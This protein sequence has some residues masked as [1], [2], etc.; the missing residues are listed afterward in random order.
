MVIVAGKAIDFLGITGFLIL[1]KP[2]I[3]SMYHRSRLPRNDGVLNTEAHLPFVR[4]SFRYFSKLIEPVILIINYFR[5]RA[6]S[7]QI[8]TGTAVVTGQ[9]KRVLSDCLRQH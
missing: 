5:Y 8:F 1:L 9:R 7:H 6:F 4:S 3:I 2:D